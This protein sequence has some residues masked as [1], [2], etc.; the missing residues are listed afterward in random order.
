MNFWKIKLRIF[1]ACIA[2]FLIAPVLIGRV[3]AQGH[4]YKV[5]VNPSN[6]ISNISRDELS[7]IFMKKASK[8]HDGH[9]AFAVDL[10]ANSPVRDTFSRDVHG[11]PESAV[12]AYWQQQLFSG[13]DVPPAE[14]SEGSAMDFV[15][16]NAGGIAYVSGGAPTDGVKVIGVTD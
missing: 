8:F 12:E 2:A 7:R 10:P 11:K 9:P 13:R 4:G 16:S 3:G 1:L 15:R 14:K 5:I 6:P